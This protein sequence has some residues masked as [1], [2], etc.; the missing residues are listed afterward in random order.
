[1]K[2]RAPW[3]VAAFTLIA[4]GFALRRMQACG[5]SW[6]EARFE[7]PGIFDVPRE[8]I[9]QGEWGILRPGLPYDELM[10]VYRQLSGLEKPHPAAEVQ[11]ATAHDSFGE[12][13]EAPNM[14]WKELRM[15]VL[16]DLPFPAEKDTFETE[17]YVT[18]TRVPPAARSSATA[19]LAA[20]IKEHGAG[21]LAVKD[22]VLAQDMV[23]SSTP[24]QPRYP[25]AVTAPPWLA[26]Q[27]RY[28]IAAARFYASDWDNARAAFLDIAR[29][30]SSP[31]RPWGRY[32]AARCWVRQAELD[33]PD[34][35]PRAK[36]EAYARAQKLL[37]EMLQ[38][39]GAKAAHDSARE[40]R[41]LTR[42]R[43]QPVAL[44]EEFLKDQERPRPEVP[45]EVASGKIDDC[46]RFLGKVST[47][48]PA[49]PPPESDLGRW[50]SA[51]THEVLPWKV[52]EQ[53]AL[54][55][56]TAR[57]TLPWLV[58]ALATATHDTPALGPLK[59]AAAK[60]P[61]TSPIAPTLRWHLLR[62]DLGA[63][64]GDPL[65]ARL[66]AALKQ[67]DLPPWAINELR[68]QRQ[69]LAKDLP[70]WFA[71]AS[72]RVTATEDDY[73]G[74]GRQLPVKNESDERF[75]AAAARSISGGLPLARTVELLKDPRIP[76]TARWRVAHA[77]WMKAVLLNQW[78]QARALNPYLQ[79]ELGQA[80]ATA[81]RGTDPVSLRFE[82]ALLVMDWPGLRPRLEG[83]LGRQYAEA[84]EGDPTG[85]NALKAFDLLRDNWWCAGG[86][87]A[88]GEVLDSSTAAIGS[89]PFLTPQE[90]SQARNESEQ[91][92]KLPSA[93]SWFGAAV[94]D[95]AVA[96]PDDR[97]VPEALHNVVAATRSPMCPGDDVSGAS[98][99][100][101]QLLH[102]RFPK[103]PWTRK[104]PYHY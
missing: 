76:P 4:G 28:Q 50:L 73:Y 62:L 93:Q 71:F 54:A 35:D 102:K 27:R 16:G 6:A 34:N 72:R 19:T 65:A 18:V 87:V 30:A 45:G 100:A 9:P 96:H 98:K 95:F 5:P 75:E 1:V 94:V 47:Q 63:L 101:F 32:L 92:Q 21:D 104:T 2:R 80:A 15:K 52:D 23:F 99:R 90:Q 7:D 41:E 88:R 77:A 31:W 55:A 66:D 79:H 91:M 24:K 29:D 58:A 51:M 22:W 20:L 64:K 3:I 57:P 13:A 48:G 46:R 39:P 36:V 61:A 74:T 49:M 97:R 78:D 33:L 14:K 70:T 40:Y 84:G 10:I 85:E 103:D 89:V 60:V 26:A 83:G 25:P 44:L 82:L 12:R 38:D 11:R 59:T 86:S 43:T 67:K 53:A 17:R 8:R 81:L 37:E 68:R 56:W 69:F 42:Y